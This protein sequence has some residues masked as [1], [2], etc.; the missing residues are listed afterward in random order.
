M[1]PGQ[2]DSESARREA[3]AA[4]VVCN[5]CLVR[6]ECLALSLRH[7]GISQHG[8]WGGLI[9]ADRGR[10]RRP[11]AAGPQRTLRTGRLRNDRA[12]ASSPECSCG[13]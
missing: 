2:G 5:R 1:V 3:A 13:R 12:A 4:I 8:T 6:D 7:W 11:Q 9:A 10:L